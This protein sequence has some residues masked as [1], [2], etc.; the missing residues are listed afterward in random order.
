MYNFVLCT[1]CVV[2]S[3]SSVVFFFFFVVLCINCVVLCTIVLFYVSIM[4]FY[5]LFMSIVLFY[6]FMSIVLFYVLFVSTL[7]FCVL[8]MCKC[9]PYYCHRV[10]TQ[11]QLNISYHFNSVFHYKTCLIWTA[12]LIL[13]A[14]MSWY[15]RPW[16]SD[17]KFYV[18]FQK[19]QR[20]A[21]ASRIQCPL[22][23]FPANKWY[24]CFNYTTGPFTE[25]VIISIVTH[26]IFPIHISMDSF[27]VLILLLHQRMHINW[28]HYHYSF[29]TQF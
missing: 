21:L 28:K 6:V 11:L 10:V 13:M 15:R 18:T 19:L 27:W 7:L 25:N 8:F 4:L 5:L 9:V 22:Q 1:S 14:V 3:I 26:L 24:F 20:S 12:A 23:A 29:K 2:P 16:L 17:T